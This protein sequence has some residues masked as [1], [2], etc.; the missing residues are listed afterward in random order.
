MT[1]TVTSAAELKQ[2]LSQASGGETILLAAGDYGRLDISTKYASTVT[3]KSADANNPAEI[4]EM[5]LNGASNVAFD[6]VVFDYTFNGQSQSYKPFQIS[7]STNI[8]IT[9]SVFS[10]DLPQGVSAT[11]DGYGTGMG[12]HIRGSSQISVTNSE[13]LNWYKAMNVGSSTD[14]TV[15]GNNI[16][17]IRSDGMYFD[18][19]Q[20]VVIENNYIH[21]FNRSLNSGDHGDF[22]QFSKL[23]GP[24]GDITI[25]GNVLDMGSGDYAQSI[26]MGNGKSSP[27]DPSMFYTNVL[28]DN[29]TIYNGHTH[30]ITVSGAKD[31]TITDNS[32]LAVSGSLTGGVSVPKINVSS[33]SQNVT[34]D[35]NIVSTVVGYS[36]QPD[37][38]VS[39]NAFVQNSDPSGAGYYDNVFSYNA[40]A[41]QD[42]YNQFS[43]KTGSIADNYDAGSDMTAI[44]SPISYDA[45][46]GTTAVTA[47]PSSG[48]TAGVI[49]PSA[50]S[51]A[52]DDG[53]TA[54]DDGMQQPAPGE[55]LLDPGTVQL[56]ADQAPIM[57]FDDFVLDIAG[58]ANSGQAIFKG[59]AIVVDTQNGPAIHLDGSDDYVKLGRLNEFEA[60]DQLAFTVEFARD[61]ADGSAQRLVWN[62]KKIGLTLTDDGLIAHVANNDAKFHKGFKATNIGLNDTEMHE[63]MVLV[64]QSSDRLQVLV[65]G[66]VVIDRSDVDFDF[67]GG[68]E[69][70]WTLGTPWGRDV[71]GTISKFAI[72]DEVQFVD[73]T[74]YDDSLLG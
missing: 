18:G 55:T 1:I 72:D 71:E 20:R 23:L 45:W 51:T 36:G 39:S 15:S 73:T 56:D 40:I 2:A 37:W 69:Y 21:D 28:I 59:D 43:V 19:V 66:Q 65:D 44:Q 64:D 57:V 13:F 52:P 14:I 46:V 38:S 31:L 10:G 6:G 61:V 34:I 25:Q 16:H 9:G 22:I 3:I 58:A 54:P 62:H 17:S 48:I 35:Q 27:S 8:D 74:V 33:G 70:G 42:G 7:N 30:G 60:S 53:T 67:S 11:A 24:S 47:P 49:Q 4:S 63:I 41:A 68:R 26:F 29:N 5:R 12:L 32:V 50:G